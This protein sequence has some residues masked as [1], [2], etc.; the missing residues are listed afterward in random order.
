MGRWFES[1][2]RYCD[3]TNEYVDEMVIGISF[4]KSVKDTKKFRLYFVRVFRVFRGS[5]KL[6]AWHLTAFRFS[7]YS[8]RWSQTILT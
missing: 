8:F 2:H 4:P 3:S 5:G 1:N 6:G 7:R